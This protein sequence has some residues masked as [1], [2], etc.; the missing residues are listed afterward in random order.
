MRRLIFIIGMCVLCAAPMCAQAVL[1]AT[2]TQPAATLG[3]AQGY[4][5]NLYV[6]A[7]PKRLLT[8][9]CTGPFGGPIVCTAPVTG[10]PAGAHTASLTATDIQ[11]D[12]L[13]P[14]ESDH[15]VTVTIPGQKPAG[16]TS[17]LFLYR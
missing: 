15:S 8:A 5:Y 1:T 3:I 10:V 4:Q 17:L 13:N 6:D 7:L 12:P 2:W 9:T 16:P 11:S 14:I